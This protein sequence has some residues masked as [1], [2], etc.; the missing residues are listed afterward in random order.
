M[1]VGGAVGKVYV[2]WSVSRRGG[3]EI[4]K[5]GGGISVSGV[6][7]GVPV[8][9]GFVWGLSLISEPE[10]SSGISGPRSC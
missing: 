5:C 8:V 1:G 7:G 4:V 9:W 3:V 10:C 2:L 6:E